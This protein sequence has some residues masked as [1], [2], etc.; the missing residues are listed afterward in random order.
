MHRQFN[1]S[2]DDIHTIVH[3]LRIA[4]VRFDDDART[5][6]LAKQRRLAEQFK[7][8]AEDSRLLADQLEE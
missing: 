6:E 7:Q 3:G 5:M 2:D 1:L 8:Q 4:A